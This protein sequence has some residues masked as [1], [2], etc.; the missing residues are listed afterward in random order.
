MNDLKKLLSGYN[1]RIGIAGLTGLAI[2]YKGLY[3]VEPGFLSI[4]FNNFTGVGG[5]TFREGYHVLVPFIEK[6]IIC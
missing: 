5:L 4:K 6:A 2:I 1:V 3:R